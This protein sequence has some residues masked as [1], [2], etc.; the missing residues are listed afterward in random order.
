MFSRKNRGQCPAPFVLEY[1]QKRFFKTEEGTQK[2]KRLQEKERMVC[3]SHETIWHPV[4]LRVSS[5]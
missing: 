1:E 2:I 4:G 5:M 3:I